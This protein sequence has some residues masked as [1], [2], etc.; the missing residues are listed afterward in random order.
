MTVTLMNPQRGPAIATPGSDGRRRSPRPPLNRR[1]LLRNSR[2][3]VI[4]AL[5]RDISIGGIGIRCGLATAYLLNFDGAD[6]VAGQ[7]GPLDLKLAL[8]FA[9]GLYEFEARTRLHYQVGRGADEALLGLRFV[10]MAETHRDY[11][12]AYLVQIHRRLALAE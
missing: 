4:P 5:A 7:G 11:L 6:G 2:G 1:I 10:G 9:E 3:N 12:F 8:P